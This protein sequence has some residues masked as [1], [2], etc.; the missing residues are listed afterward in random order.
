[1]VKASLFRKAIGENTMRQPEVAARLRELADELACEELNDLA[2]EIARRPAGQRAPVSSA[3]MTE[4]LRRRIREMKAANPTLS[5]AEI[6]RQLNVNPGRVS[7]TLKG[8][9][10]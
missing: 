9:R 1:L 3:P 2:D 7:E 10:A 8:K 6:G 5:H 4:E